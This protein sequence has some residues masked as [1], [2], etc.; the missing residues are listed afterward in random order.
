MKLEHVVP[1]AVY[2]NPYCTACSGEETLPPP[3]IILSKSSLSALI[4]VESNPICHVYLPP[5]TAGY[6]S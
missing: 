6:M 5:H 1:D 3:P 4:P 2:K